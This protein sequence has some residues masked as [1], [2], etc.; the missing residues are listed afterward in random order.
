[1]IPFWFDGIDQALNGEPTPRPL[2]EYVADTAD[3]VCIMDYRDFA[4]GPDGL[5]QHA[6]N[7]VAYGPAW[8]AVETMNVPPEKIT[9]YEEG[10]AY[11][12]GELDTLHDAY[13]DDANY[14][15]IVIHYFQPYKKMAP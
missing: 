11:M 15:G 2:N 10:E 6:A 4:E 5:I 3:I 13:A 14:N 9:F 1:M 12:E 8:I 7:E